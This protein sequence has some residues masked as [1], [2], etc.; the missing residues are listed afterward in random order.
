MRRNAAIAGGGLF[1]VLLLLAGGIAIS[2]VAGRRSPSTPIDAGR[3]WFVPQDS[4]GKPDRR[5]PDGARILAQQDVAPGKR[6]ILYAWRFTDTTPPT[7]LMVAPLGI[8]ETYSRTFPWEPRVG[9]HPAGVA[10]RWATLPVG[11]EFYVG[12]LPAGFNGL[13]EPVATVWGLS[14]RGVQVRVTWSDGLVTLAPLQQVAFLQTRPDPNY[15]QQLDQ[16]LSVR[17]VELL[18]DTGGSRPLILNREARRAS[19]D[20]A[21]G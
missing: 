19:A 11:D 20:S 2:L 14:R 5:I 10:G 15:P 1:I 21:T 7:A 12:S 17:T 9:W 18:D 13:S 4:A 6:I 16:R 8:Q 3:E